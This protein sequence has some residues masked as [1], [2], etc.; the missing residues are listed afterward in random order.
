MGRLSWTLAVRQMQVP[1]YILSYRSLF[2]RLIETQ[3]RDKAMESIVGG[4][5]DEI[6]I[7]ESSALITLGLRRS[8]T[9]VDVGCGSGRLAFRLRD[10]LAGPFTGTDI[11]EEALVFASEKCRR[12]DW[13]FIPHAEPSIP[14]GDSTADFVTFFSVFT[15]LLDE[16]IYR[17]LSDARRVAKPGGRIVFSFLDFECDSHWPVFES[18]LSDTDPKRVINKFISK[19]AIRRWADVLGL[20]VDAI[21]NGP[22]PWIQLTEPFTYTDGRRAEG[23]VEF[24]QS[25]AVLRREAP[26]PSPPGPHP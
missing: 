21:F 23:I 12:P 6:G 22:E 14:A 15:H 16:D 4:Q 18:T 9:L 11:L 7:L 10:Y 5:Y 26:D 24:G 8:D 3:G 13:R 17:F 2:S 1:D 25:V 20:R 19:G